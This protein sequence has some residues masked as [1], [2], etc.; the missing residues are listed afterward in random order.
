MAI[1]RCRKEAQKSRDVPLSQ[2]VMFAVQL[3]AMLDE[4][5]M[6]R[7]NCESVCVAY[8]CLAVYNVHLLCNTIIE[9]SVKFQPPLLQHHASV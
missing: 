5:C 9:I 8:A 4:E 1:L 3:N 2:G 6:V 7:R